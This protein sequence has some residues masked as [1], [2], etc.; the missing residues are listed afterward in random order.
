M[1]HIFL[2][3]FNIPGGFR[4]K[5]HL[6]TMTFKKMKFTFSYS[7]SVNKGKYVSST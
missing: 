1:L 6:T 7:T 3:L 2:H 4:I 5:D